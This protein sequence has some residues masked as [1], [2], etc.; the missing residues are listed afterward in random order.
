MRQLG[1]LCGFVLLN[2]AVLAAAR[3]KAGQS[4]ETLSDRKNTRQ[5]RNKKL[6]ANVSNAEDLFF[7][8]SINVLGEHPSDLYIPIWFSLYLQLKFDFDLYVQTLK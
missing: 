7:L 3:P 8:T 6:T 1:A 5:K 2:L 4:A